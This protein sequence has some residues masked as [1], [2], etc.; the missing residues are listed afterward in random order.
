MA[1]TL[2]LSGCVNTLWPRQSDLH[3][4]DDIFQIHLQLLMNVYK[5]V[6]ILPQANCVIY[7]ER[8]RM[9]S[10]FKKIHVY[11]NSFSWKKLLCYLCKF[12]FNVFPNFQIKI[13]VTILSSCIELYCSGAN[14]TGW[15][16]YMEKLS[17]LIVRCEGSHWSPGTGPM[18]GKPPF[19][20]KFTAQRTSN[21][22]IWCF[23][24][25]Q[26]EQTAHQ[27]HDREVRWGGLMLI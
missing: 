24:G 11:S 20:S 1:A 3:F 25:C 27:T 16:H 10:V 6:A 19:T 7:L 2:S 15:R 14:A 17:A 18:W 21:T 4:E 5:M 9:A 12:H 22:K 26:P 13:H 8:N 23:L